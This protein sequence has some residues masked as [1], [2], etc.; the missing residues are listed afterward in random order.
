[1]KLIP[2]VFLTF[3]SL[4]AFAGDMYLVC[5]NEKDNDFLSASIEDH[6]ATMLLNITESQPVKLHVKKNKTSQSTLYNLEV[7]FLREKIS[8]EFELKIFEEINLGNYTCL[9]RD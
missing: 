4:T 5:E 6:G 8:E 1:M 9:V 3:F 7:N 2:I